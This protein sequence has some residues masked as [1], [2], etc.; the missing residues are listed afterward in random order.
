[1]QLS[2]NRK[3]YTCQPDETVLEALLRQNVTIPHSCSHQICLS[4][5]MCSLGGSPPP[6]SQV[7]LN[8]TL[9]LQ[10]YFLACGCKPEADMEISLPQESFAMEVPATVLSVHTLNAGVLSISLQC[11]D[12][13]LD[14]KSGQSVILLNKDNIGTQCPIV[15]PSDNRLTGQLEIHLDLSRDACFSTWAIEKLCTGTRVRLYGSIGRMIYRA[16]TAAQTIL[17]A[18]K[19]A[20]LSTLLGIMQDIFSSE[21]TGKIY[22]FHEVDTLADLYLTDELSE[23]G[24]YYPNFHYIPCVLQSPQNNTVMTSANQR[25]RHTVTDLIGGQAFICGSKH[26]VLSIQKQS[27]LAGC[28]TNDIFVDITT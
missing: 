8:E 24:D 26:F 25:I 17:L 12:V 11:E 18:A 13:I 1:M 15:S 3:K 28:N 4:C 9:K 23:I 27:Y 19:N 16:T 20:G 21:H 22:L 5:L 2:Y 10:N 7:G 6:A 14:Y